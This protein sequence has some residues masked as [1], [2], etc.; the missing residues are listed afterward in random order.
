MKSVE[1]LYIT[2]D[3]DIKTRSPVLQLNVAFPL[4]LQR[5]FSLALFLGCFGKSD[6]RQERQNFYELYL[7]TSY[8]L[9]FGCEFNSIVGVYIK[10]KPCN[11]LDQSGW[12]SY[13]LSQ[14]RE[15]Q[16][17]TNNCRIS[18]LPGFSK[19]FGRI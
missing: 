8:C 5:F 16:D 3:H 15:K 18:I 17:A 1:R 12:R 7:L 14:S 13:I 11:A 2:N 6:N 4:F 10:I 9:E 19:N